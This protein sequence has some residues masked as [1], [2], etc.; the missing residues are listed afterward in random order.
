MFPI[1]SPSDRAEDG[2]GIFDSDAAD[3]TVDQALEATFYSLDEATAALA[4]YNADDQAFV[5]AI[6]R[7]DEEGEA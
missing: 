6:E 3:Y 7:A 5:H 4:R 2:Y 1:T